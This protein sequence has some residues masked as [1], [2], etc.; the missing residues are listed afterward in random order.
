LSGDI[1]QS[2]LFGG[3]G[4]DAVFDIAINDDGMVFV[5]GSTESTDFPLLNPLQ[6][7]KIEEETAFVS[8]FSPTLDLLLATYWGGKEYDMSEIPED[9]FYFEDY[10]SPRSK[11][12]CILADCNTFILS[13]Y[14]SNNTTPMKNAYQD[15]NPPSWGP[16]D[17]LFLT[18]FL[19]G[20]K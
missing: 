12:K 20:V 16:F 2:K 19:I 7:Q 1:L 3:N 15:N 18:Q 9:H 13:G 4:D 14:T 11:G 6:N 10:Q 8:I 5:T 17:S